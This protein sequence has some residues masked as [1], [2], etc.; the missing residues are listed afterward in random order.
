MGYPAF[1]WLGHGSTKYSTARSL[2]R[3]V[4]T[5]VRRGLRG[6]DAPPFRHPAIRPVAPSPESTDS[7]YLRC[8]FCCQQMELEMALKMKI[9]V[10][11]T[12]Q[13]GTLKAEDM[14]RTQHRESE[15]AR[16]AMLFTQLEDMERALKWAD[17]CSGAFSDE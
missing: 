11:G 17:R 3:H 4:S 7:V 2:K 15:R 9:L 13:L 14:L 8:Q 12:C 16:L 1:S 6:R 10:C 5:D